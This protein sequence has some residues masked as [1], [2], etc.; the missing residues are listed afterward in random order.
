[1]TLQ[2]GHRRLQRCRQYRT[3]AAL[4]KV[5]CLSQPRADGRQITW[6]AAIKRQPRQS[7]I[8]IGHP[9]QAY[10]KLLGNLGVFNPKGD[11][12]KARG[13]LSQ[14]KRG[15]RQA[16]LHKAR[17][18]GSDSEIETGQQGAAPL[19]RQSLCQLKIAARCGIDL[20][21]TGN[22]LRHGWSQQRQLAFLGNFEILN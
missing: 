20:H 8:Q 15:C 21:H 7:P 11:G 22:R 17:A 10:A 16:P 18:A 4:C 13:N 12:I 14:I 2:I 19:A 5:H 3:G 6:P 1:M 9:A